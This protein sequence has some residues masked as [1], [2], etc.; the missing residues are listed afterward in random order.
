MID[1]T[2]LLLNETYASTAIG[3]IEVFYSAGLLWND[4]KGEKPEPRYHVTI[5]SSDG[6][7]VM[8]AYPL[9][10][11]PQVSIHD[12]KHADLIIVPASGLDLENQFVRQGQP[13]EG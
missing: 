2:V 5:A 7:D 13:I 9:R 12:V 11:R 1:V 8:S 3:P 4:L 10:L 6:A